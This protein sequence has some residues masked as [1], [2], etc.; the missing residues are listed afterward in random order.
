MRPPIDANPSPHRPQLDP[1]AE[2][3][4]MQPRIDPKAPRWYCKVTTL[5]LHRCCTGPL[6]GHHVHGFWSDSGLLLGWRDNTATALILHWCYTSI[7]WVLNWYCSGMWLRPL[8]ERA[9]TERMTAR[10]ER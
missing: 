5:V 6:Q 3:T 2:S 4:P 1:D 7:A 8:A 10:I 9:D